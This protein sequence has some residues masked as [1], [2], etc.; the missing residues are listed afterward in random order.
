LLSLLRPWLPDGL[1]GLAML[2]IIARIAHLS[3]LF[4]IP[5]SQRALI[6]LLR[7]LKSMTDDGTKAIPKE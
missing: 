2:S 6:G 3:G 4:A 5:N 1:T 7:G